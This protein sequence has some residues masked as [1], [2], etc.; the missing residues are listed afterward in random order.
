MNAMEIEQI[1]SVQTRDE[2]SNYS[3]LRDTVSIHGLESD[4]RLCLCD[5]G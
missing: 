5:V 2:R 1:R 3:S 4:L